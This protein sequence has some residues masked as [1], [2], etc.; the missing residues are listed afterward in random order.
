MRTAALL[1]LVLWSTT[2]SAEL[3]GKATYYTVESC[4]REGTSGVKTANG[5]DYDELALTA[6]LPRRDFGGLYRVCA[7]RQAGRCLVLRHND[8]GP[9]RRAR[10]RGV[11]IDL[12]PAAFDALGGTRGCKAWGCWG[13]LDVTVEQITQEERQ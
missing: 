9:G 6:A 4:K 13:E 3:A 11:V 1:G 10:A 8:F 5:E 2:A 7:R 12:T